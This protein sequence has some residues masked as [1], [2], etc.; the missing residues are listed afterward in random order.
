M[1]P[2]EF[3]VPDYMVP[4]LMRY[5]RQGI[6]PGDF[7]QAVLRNDLR[8]AVGRADDTNR[9][10]LPA[11]VTYLYSMAPAACWGSPENVA[12]WIKRH[13]QERERARGTQA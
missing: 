6:P 9:H 1:S 7:L 11:Y 3:G 12:A 8:Q 4:G 2:E 10:C 13:E 5:I